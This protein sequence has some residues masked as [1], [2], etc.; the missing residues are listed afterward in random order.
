MKRSF[1]VR[2]STFGPIGNLK[3]SGTI[4]TLLTMPLVYAF[5]SLHFWYALTAIMIITAGSLFVVSKA[6]KAFPGDHDPS[7]IVIDELVGC[8]VTFVGVPL[9]WSTVLIGFVCFRLFDIFKPVGIKQIEYCITPWGIVLDDLVA[10]LLANAV[11][12]LFLWWL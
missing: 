3:G 2:I 10:G 12:Q 1:L 4:A 6:C 7:A 11:V 9:T 5:S 8:L